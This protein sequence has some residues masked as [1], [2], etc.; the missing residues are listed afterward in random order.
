MKNNNVIFGGE[1]LQTK[2]Q[3]FDKQDLPWAHKYAALMM[4]QFWLPE[5]IKLTRDRVLFDKIPEN[6]KNVFKQNL[7]YQIYMDTLQ[8]RGLES[9]LLEQ[10]SSETLEY[11]IRIW[12]FFETIHSRS[13][14]HIV[15]TLFT[16]AD[17]FF[18]EIENNE[19]IK[20][21]IHKEKYMYIDK[22]CS[23]E[24]LLVTIAALEGI[25]FYFSFLITY[26]INDHTNGALPG[27][28]NILRLIQNDEAIHCGFNAQIIRYIRDNP[29]AVGK[30]YTKNIITDKVKQIFKTVVQ[31]EIDFAA[32]NIPPEL[33]ELNIHDVE[34]FIKH[35]ANKVCYM[36]GENA[37]YPEFMEPD[38]LTQ[39]FNNYCDP[40]KQ[41]AALQE[42]NN[43]AY[44]LGLVRKD[45]DRGNKW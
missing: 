42:T 19:V 28:S 25:R 2:P 30:T 39:W 3:R 4:A 12:S 21:R 20:D 14:T 34:Y 9:F 23:I 1:T 6:L 44:E 10:C 5:E 37:L 36:I 40:N 29:E 22:N 13:Y 35:R 15:N 7:G 38:S 26:A 24:E 8:S 11:P 41:A 27:V 18:D 16:D 17:K 33:T 43:T 32:Q 45:Q 31:D